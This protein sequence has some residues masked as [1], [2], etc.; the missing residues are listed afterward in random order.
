MC[1]PSF[2]NK[3]FSFQIKR[4]AGEVKLENLVSNKLER[5]KCPPCGDTSDGIFFSL[6][7]G[8]N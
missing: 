6:G 1:Q 5:V 2:Q 3:G 4:G 8:V 7:V